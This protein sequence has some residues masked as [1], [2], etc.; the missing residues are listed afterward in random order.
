MARVKYPYKSH[1]FFRGTNWWSNQ[2]GGPG[3]WKILSD[4][5]NYTIGDDLWEFEDNRF[6]FKT[7]ADLTMFMLRWKC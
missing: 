1:Q 5:C 4:W 6:V 2:N 7:E 3:E